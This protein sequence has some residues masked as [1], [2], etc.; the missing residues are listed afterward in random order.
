[1]TGAGEW[2][3]HAVKPMLAPYDDPDILFDQLSRLNSFQN[4]GDLVVFGA[5]IDGKQVNFENQAGGHASIGGDQLHPFVL[6]K[7][8]WGIDLAAVT[9]AHQLHQVL[10]D[11]RDRLASQPPQG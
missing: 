5:F 7:K 6:A 10:S 4:A 1:M 2:R 8:E 3:G 9:G 11:L